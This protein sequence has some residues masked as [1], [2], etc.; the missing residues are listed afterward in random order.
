MKR[1]CQNTYQAT[2]PGYEY[3]TNITYRIEACDI[4]GNKAIKDNEYHVVPEYSSTAIYLLIII[5]ISLATTLMSNNLITA[6]HK[7]Q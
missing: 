2:I 3:C 1:T 7:G 5:T 6:N 4:V